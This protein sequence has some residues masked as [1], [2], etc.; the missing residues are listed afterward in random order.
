MVIEQKIR[1]ATTD[2]RN[3]AEMNKADTFA[4][5]YLWNLNMHRLVHVLQR[6]EFH[7]IRPWHELKAYEI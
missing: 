6:F 3:R 4:E 7:A 5:I 1:R 2:S